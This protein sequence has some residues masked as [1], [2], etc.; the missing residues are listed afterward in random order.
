MVNKDICW[1]IFARAKSKRLPNKCY[2]DLDGEIILERLVS[3]AEKAGITLKDIFLCTSEDKSC[4]KLS[5]IA[6]QK[7]I[8]VISGAEDFPLK[9]ICSSKAKKVLGNYKH[10]VRICGDSPFYSFNLAL[11]A[12]KKYKEHSPDFFCITNTR[13]R[14]FPNGLSLEIYSC[15]H[16]FEMLNIYI[17]LQEIEHM[18]DLINLSKKEIIDV[19][20]TTN[21]LINFPKKLTIDTYSDYLYICDLINT[22]LEKELEYEIINTSFS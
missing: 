1:L 20:T 21:F 19:V 3:K 14:N 22:D 17:E 2:L 5:N 8:N 18:S 12:Y 7:K 11:R 13:K 4:D 15:K 9:R 10:L 6:T 16:L